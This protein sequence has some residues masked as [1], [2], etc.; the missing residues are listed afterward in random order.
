VGICIS[1]GEV[2][3]DYLDGKSATLMQVYTLHRGHTTAVVD[4]FDWA[5]FR[6]GKQPALGRLNRTVYFFAVNRYGPLGWVCSL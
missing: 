3:H 1:S 6:D 4:S 2:G 5:R